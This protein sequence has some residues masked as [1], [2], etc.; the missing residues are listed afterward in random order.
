MTLTLTCYR[1]EGTYLSAKY[2][3]DRFMGALAYAP[4]SRLGLS[5]LSSISYDL[6]V[7]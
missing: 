2:A 3:F 5:A 4:P 1:H 7:Q 6:A